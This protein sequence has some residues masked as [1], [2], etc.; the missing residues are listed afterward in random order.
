[1]VMVILPRRMAWLTERAFH[2]R[3][4]GWI[5]K[6]V[7]P[8]ILVIR[9]T[10]G[11]RVWQD[12]PCMLCQFCK[13]RYRDS[14]WTLKM[15]IHWKF[16]SK[17]KISGRNCHC[18]FK[19]HYGVQALH[20]KLFSAD[21]HDRMHQAPLSFAARKPRNKVNFAARKPRN[22]VNFAARKPRDK[23]NFAARRSRDRVN[24]AAGSLVNHSV[25]QSASAYLSFQGDLP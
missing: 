17:I 10:E 5:V 14:V 3:F 15:S 8:S 23:V 12:T 24:F 18:I 22:K 21:T 2:E 9:K 11:V 25:K 7:S 4:L 6:K 19:L 13:E 16:S 20:C 1:M